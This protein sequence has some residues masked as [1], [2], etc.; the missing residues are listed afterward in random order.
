MPA[1]LGELS[2]AMI[3]RIDQSSNDL[4]FFATKNREQ[5]DALP[6]P[7]LIPPGDPW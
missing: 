3:A 7:R 4:R 6:E 2:F 5:G 1:T